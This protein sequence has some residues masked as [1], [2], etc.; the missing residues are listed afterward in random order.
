MEKPKDIAP[1]NGQRLAVILSVER[2]THWSPGTTQVVTKVQLNG[3]YEV[4][5]S[6]VNS[7][8]NSPWLD[9][10]CAFIHGGSSEIVGHSDFNVHDFLVSAGYEVSY[11]LDN[12]D[13][14]ELS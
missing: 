12:T 14:K 8:G 10:T 1:V 2:P 11:A 13:Q 5:F 3:T 7:H 9:E 6:S 4:D